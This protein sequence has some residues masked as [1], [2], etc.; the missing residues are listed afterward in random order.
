[1]QRRLRITLVLRPSTSSLPLGLVAVV[2]LLAVG[3]ALVSQHVFDMQPCPWCVLQ[4]MIYLAT[5]LACLA[6]VVW[7]SRLGQ[8]LSTL[9]VLDLAAFGLAA[10]L[11]QHFVAASSTS[12][13]LTYADRFISSTN[14]DSL[15]PDVFSPRASCADAAVRL[16]GIQ[17]DVWSATLFLLI[18]AAATVILLRYRKANPA[19]TSSRNPSPIRRVPRM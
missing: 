18:G 1:M 5:A 3:A 15:L 9:L 16:L 6:G 7:R 10:A 17:Y 14:L 19:Q 12:C 2:C 11:W 13:A 8:I 4:R